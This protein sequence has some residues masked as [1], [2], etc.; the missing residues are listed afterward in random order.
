MKTVVRFQGDQP[1]GVAVNGVPFAHH[2]GG[3][4]ASVF[5]ACNGHI[6]AHNHM[7]H[8]H[9][10]PTCLLEN[11]GGEVPADRSYWASNDPLEQLQDWPEVGKPSP[12]VGYALDGFF[13]MGPYDADGDLQV[14]QSV[15]GRSE[16]DECNGKVGKD[17]EYRYYLTPNAPYNVACFKGAT[18]GTYNDQRTS[19][20]ACPKMGVASVWCD[21]GDPDCELK[22]VAACT[23]EPYDGPTFLFQ[24]N[25]KLEGERWDLYSLVFGLMFLLL[26]TVAIS[27]TV[28]IVK[29][30]KEKKGNVA[31][32]LIMYIM[33]LTICW[34]RALV[35]LVDPHYTKEV[36]SPY[37]VGILYGISYPAINAAIGLMLFVL[38]ELV[39]G[40]KSM[41]AAKTGFLPQTKKVYIVMSVLQFVTQIFADS[42]RA[43][44][45]N[46][47]FLVVCQV[48]FICWGFVVCVV[49]VMWGHGLWK[50]LSPSFRKRCKKFFINVLTST[51]VGIVLIIDAIVKLTCT[52][53]EDEYFAEMVFMRIT[54]L[55]ACVLF[56]YAMSSSKSFLTKMTGS[57]FSRVSAVS[58]RSSR[59]GS[60]RAASSSRRASGKSSG[61]GSSASSSAA[62][63]S[64]GSS[65]SS[66][67]EDASTPKG[68]G[69]KVSP[70]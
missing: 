12:V 3:D 32:K 51:F 18:I 25:P 44:G 30:D 14:G 56:L 9:M 7:Y 31:V 41:A 64:I 45:Y 27:E 2:K 19:N 43:A 42:M 29:P 62:S 60:S 23:D 52:L 38:Y 58:G 35:A 67:V 4:L 22:M 55:L 11:L 13:I 66:T 33:V 16:L 28:W 37:L 68:K 49:G 47:S 46:F 54:E 53:T 63:S 20:A 61:A 10:I 24:I 8:Y 50:T 70:A 65:A 21:V 59:V 15:P 48:Y 36:L 6:D 26:S 1:I 69:N 5:D 39:E 34:S 17:G 40:A 57:A